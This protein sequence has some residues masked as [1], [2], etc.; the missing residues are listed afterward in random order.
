MIVHIEM[1]ETQPAGVS[2]CR[3]CL[4]DPGGEIRDVSCRQ[5]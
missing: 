2:S 5:V 1:V 4:F 3:G